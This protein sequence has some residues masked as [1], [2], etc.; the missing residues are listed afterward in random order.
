MRILYYRPLNAIFFFI[1][2]YF[3]C[4]FHLSRIYEYINENSRLESFASFES[5]KSICVELALKIHIPFSFFE[6]L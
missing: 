4:L 5:K 1:Q 2:L 3:V 6:Q